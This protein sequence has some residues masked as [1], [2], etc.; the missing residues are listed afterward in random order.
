M[1]IS[2]LFS[3]LGVIHIYIVTFL[4]LLS[5]YYHDDWIEFLYYAI[6]LV[7]KLFNI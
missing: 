2:I 1:Y 5:H 6:N 4:Y 7:N 3:V